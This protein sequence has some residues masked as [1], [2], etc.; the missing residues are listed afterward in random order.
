[1]IIK[2]RNDKDTVLS[3][4][5]YYHTENVGLKQVTFDA[6]VEATKFAFT[7]TD[8][9]LMGMAAFNSKGS[10]MF[11][12]YIEQHMRGV[13]YL[14]GRTDIA[15][16][17]KHYDGKVFV[18]FAETFPFNSYKFP[19]II[20]DAIHNGFKL[21]LCDYSKGFGISSRTKVET[22]GV[23]TLFYSSYK[24]QY[25]SNA[26]LKKSLGGDVF[27][28]PIDE[29]LTTD[30]LDGRNIMLHFSQ[31]TPELIEHVN[32]KYEYAV[33]VISQHQPLATLFGASYNEYLY[34]E[35][36]LFNLFTVDYPY[37]EGAL[38]KDKAIFSTWQ[39]FNY[40]GSHKS[41]F[42][43]G[44][45]VVPSMLNTDDNVVVRHHL[46]MQFL[47]FV[48]AELRMPRLTDAEYEA[49]CQRYYYVAISSLYLTE[50]K[51]DFLVKAKQEKR[52]Y[53]YLLKQL[54]GSVL[55]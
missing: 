40:A 49:T 11:E 18:D 38:E 33:E 54:L 3:N 10:E 39:P 22:G 12:E 41:H 28:A 42:N 13:T 46:M 6:L 8:T 34:K 47:P 15:Y 14:E 20:I 24:G 7:I 32:S 9:V 35:D 44:T 45:G 36:T 52:P 27:N 2:L 51:I 37:K 48:K 30:I 21:T 29:D 31:L 55:V 17:R 43:V 25:N 19:F 50:E 53:A 4:N 16:S 26:V 1:M 23:P 5:G